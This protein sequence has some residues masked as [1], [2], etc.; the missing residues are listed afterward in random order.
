MQQ[1]HRVVA[2]ELRQRLSFGG[3][4]HSEKGKE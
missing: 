1:A 2:V 4:A 3:T